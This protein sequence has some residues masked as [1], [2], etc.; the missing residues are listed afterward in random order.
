M[1]MGVAFI[2]VAEH[3]VGSDIDMPRLQRVR[4]FVAVRRHSPSALVNCPMT[5]S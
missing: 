3:A 1:K 4:G 2:V 5:L